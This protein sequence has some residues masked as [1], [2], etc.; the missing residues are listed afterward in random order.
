MK[1]YYEA[2]GITIY[3][4]D[5]REVLTA[6]WW[7]DVETIDLTVTS[8]PYDTL[9]TYGGH[10]WDFEATALALW[11]VTGP[12]GVVV[13]VVGD[14]TKNGSESGTSFYQA[15]YFKNTIG[16]RLHDTMIYQKDSCP[17]P[18]TNRYY[19]AF[20][21]MF[22]FSKGA[23]KTTYLLRDKRNVW[24]RSLLTSTQ[25]NKDSSLK[26]SHGNRKHVFPELGIRTNVWKYSPGFG[27][28]SNEKI[29]H[30]HPA[31]FPYTLAAD[32]IRSWSN[33]GDLI[34]D[35]FMGSGTTLRAAKDLGRKAIGIEI[36]EKYCEIAAKRLAQMVLPLEERTA[37]P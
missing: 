32:H 10:S 22:V 13:W 12:G 18:E 5:C 11:N 30:E 6:S 33:P 7:L 36:E 14:E 17:F 16:F 28:S 15:L 9:R 37:K 27:K 3:H 20:E 8:P 29:A 2:D 23:P 4:G 24:A 21:Y 1:P 35:P 19:P 25:R 34:L 31:I 26:K